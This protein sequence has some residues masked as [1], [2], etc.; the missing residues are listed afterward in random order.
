VLRRAANA[1]VAQIQVSISACRSATGLTNLRVDK[2]LLSGGGAQ[3][4]GLADFLSA[5]LHLPVEMLESFAGIEL[6]ALPPD[7]RREVEA[8]QAHYA[9][10]VGLALEQLL[11]GSFHLS[12]LPKAVKDRR[13]FYSRRIYLWAAGILY[14]TTLLTAIVSSFILTEMR[15]RQVDQMHAVVN[16]AELQL[17]EATRL[18]DQNAALS[19][20]LETLFHRLSA[21]RRELELW[22]VMRRVTPPQIQVLK[23]ETYSERASPYEK[24]RRELS[25]LEKLA[26]KDQPPPPRVLVIMGKVTL[27]AIRSEG[28][29]IRNINVDTAQKMVRQY[30]EQ[31]KE[32]GLVDRLE[33]PMVPVQDNLE[34]RIEL[35][36][37]PGVL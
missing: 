5:R 8:H 30:G 16:K 18:R 17:G 27:E 22:S 19:G 7:R 35:A 4:P 9:T 3:L 15:R 11:P 1:L 6:G 20:E 14:A 37:K 24:P 26:K 23:L 31:L 29:L 28:R 34:F 13:D 36:L 12:L 33:I 32:S 25:L 10:A 21:S 2:L